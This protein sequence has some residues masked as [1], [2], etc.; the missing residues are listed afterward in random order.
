MSDS[1]FLQPFSDPIPPNSMRSNALDSAGYI[2]S[3]PSALGHVGPTPVCC[4]GRHFLNCEL[5]PSFCDG[6]TVRRSNPVPSP[7]HT[8]PFTSNK[9]AVFFPKTTTLAAKLEPAG[10]ILKCPDDRSHSLCV[11]LL[12]TSC[13]YPCTQIPLVNQPWLR[14]TKPKSTLA[15]V[16]SATWT[17][18]S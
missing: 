7:H 9:R 13:F 5:T 10:G 18:N 14:A 3:N 17:F 8:T 2:Y 6:V 1:A 11:I 12:L 4:A 16:T 15:S